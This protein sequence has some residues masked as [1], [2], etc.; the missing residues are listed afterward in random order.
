[1]LYAI[2]FSI[3]SIILGA[4]A[5]YFLDKEKRFGVFS[6]WIFSLVLGFTLQGFVALV[7][8][9]I[10]KDLEIAAWATLGISSV[11]CGVFWK[12]I[13]G[14]LKFSIHNSPNPSYLK[15]GITLFFVLVITGIVLLLAYQ[16]M[17]WVDG[18]PYGILKGWG[19]GAYHMDMIR[20]LAPPAAEA[21]LAE[22]EPFALN[23]PVAGGT[24]L[25]YTF[26]I[27][28]L[29]ALFLKLG[30]SFSFAWHLPLFVY[31]IGIVAGLWNIAKSLLKR[32]VLQIS[33]IAIVLFGGGLGIF[34]APLQTSTP[35]TNDLPAE[36]NQR[37]ATNDYSFLTSLWNHVSDPQYEYTHL[38]IRTGGK[39]AEKEYDKN[40]VWI[41]PA[42]SFFSHQRS[43][44]PGAALF[45]L[46]LS[47]IFA[48]WPQKQDNSEDKDSG[49]AL[50]PFSFHLSPF[51]LWFVIAGLIPLSHLHTAVVAGVFGIVT[52]LFH[53]P[54]RRSRTSPDRSSASWFRI[55]LPIL[56]ALLIAAPQIYYLLSNS[57]FS[58][59]S[60]LT[61][62][63]PSPTLWFGWMTC[64][65]NASWF[66]CDPDVAGTDTSAL[67]FWLKN[68]GVVFA[69]WII[70][71][72]A[73]LPLSFPR[74][75]LPKPRAEEGRRESKW[76]LNQVQ[77]DKE[78]DFVGISKVVLFS[79][80]FIFALG[81]LIKFQPWE[82]DNNKLLFYW[83][84][85][86]ALVFVFLVEK[87]LDVSPLKRREDGACLLHAQ[88]W[89]RQGVMKIITPL[90]PL[91]LRGGITIVIF[92][93][94]ISGAVDVF[95]RVKLGTK[96][97][98]N[99]SHFGYYGSEIAGAISFI[100]ENTPSSAVIVSASGASQFIP[101]TTG[102]SLYLGF[103]GWLWTQGRAETG[104]E[105]RRDIEI[106][107]QT[108]D[109]SVLCEKGAGYLYIDPA[110]RQEYRGFIREDISFLRSK[111]IYSNSSGA[112]YKLACNTR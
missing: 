73:F 50:S 15:R 86:S 33:F 104:A 77:D 102:R 79:G 35:T 46:F 108:G 53:L 36:I 34:L 21:G 106:F 23:H 1:M 111:Q 97:D 14:Y 85:A 62:Q 41:T 82:F 84:F 9:L 58:S 38:D 103:E 48:Y 65:H 71:L 95:A 81:N 112:L 109:P 93:S 27:N 101:M 4:A 49:T 12:K 51:W 96:P 8:S 55:F 87:L 78:K 17:I 2:L 94:L 45:F 52:F 10:T 69:A 74:R 105:R 64:T 99:V 42:I 88:A 76:I 7:L 28:F 90:T 22:S 24:P 37:P 13:F 92:L 80:I 16:S 63:N 59:G 30:S 67:W 6:R 68:F 89:R 5:L 57:I 3:F 98:K 39:P 29:S 72:I 47:G 26:F 18:F 19:D 54:F 60:S 66:Q 110:F 31:G 100:Q 70:S 40:I 43:F 83:W 32:K 44:M 91:I 107:L 61:S 11:V 75:A 25:T 20:V 56:I